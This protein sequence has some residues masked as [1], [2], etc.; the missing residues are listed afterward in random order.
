MSTPFYIVDHL[1]TGNGLRTFS[2]SPFQ[3]SELRDRTRDGVNVSRATVNASGD[4][5]LKAISRRSLFAYLTTVTT[6]ANTV[7][8]LLTLNICYPTQTVL[9]CFRTVL[10]NARG[11][12]GVLLPETNFTVVASSPPLGKV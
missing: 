7:L 1:L 10:T 4:G 6:T 5:F 8:T 3:V 9:H 2:R 11:A 12:V